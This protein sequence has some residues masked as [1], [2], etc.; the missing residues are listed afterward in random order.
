VKPA[1]NVAALREKNPPP[2]KSHAIRLTQRQTQ[3]CDK[4]WLFERL[5]FSTDP[6]LENFV[7]LA[8]M[9]KPFSASHCSFVNLA[10]RFHTECCFEL[11]EER[12]GSAIQKFRAD[13]AAE[14]KQ[15]SPCELG[16]LLIVVSA[17]D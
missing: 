9:L 1:G 17:V 14:A 8:R 16:C 11:M 6:D 7:G 10:S 4:F 3:R 2:R 15:P 13:T 12:H 5:L